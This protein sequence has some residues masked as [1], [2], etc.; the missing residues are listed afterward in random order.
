[1]RA[2]E[3]IKL[4]DI[5]IFD[6]TRSKE[7]VT[8]LMSSIKQDGLISPITVCPDFIRNNGK[9]LV[10]SGHRR[11]AAVKKLGGTEIPAIINEKVTTKK[12]LY[13]LNLTENIQRKE[14]SPMEEGRYF[15]KLIKD[16]DMSQ[17]EIATRLSVTKAY[18]SKAVQAYAEVP[19][20]YRDVIVKA[21]TKKN[22]NGKIPITLASAIITKCNQAGIPRAAQKRMFA[23]AATGEI[24]EQKVVHVVQQYNHNLT[25]A[26]NFQKIRKVGKD[27]RYHRFDLLLYSSD[28][29]ALKDS[30]GISGTEILK[31][32]IYGEIK[33][34][35]R[36]P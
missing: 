10:V 30:Y 4:K 13:I 3:N 31:K 18:V 24:S 14:V 35:I 26:E 11:L 33:K 20:K 15:T 9:Y 21:G 27:I 2:V 29:D 36:R 8:D 7:D 16:F 17:N 22:P 32:I 28:I 12:Q 25:V 5:G 23:M 6:N 34:T 19:E 1:M